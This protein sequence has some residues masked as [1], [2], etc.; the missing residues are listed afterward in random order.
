MKNLNSISI[1]LALAI[2]CSVIIISGCGRQSLT[3]DKG[4]RQLAPVLG[5]DSEDLQYINHAMFAQI[6]DGAEKV[7][8]D[9]IGIVALTSSD[10]IL[11]EGAAS[12]ITEK[13]VLRIPILAIDGFALEGPFL[14]IVHQGDRFVILPYR[15]YSDTVDMAQLHALSE[16]LEAQSIPTSAAADIEWTRRLIYNAEGSG[17]YF[18]GSSSRGG[19]GSSSDDGWGSDSLFYDADGSVHDSPFNTPLN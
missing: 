18:V 6:E 5:S 1:I 2:V 14:Q 3:L 10:L 19:S 16:L 7:D 12:S 17:V 9:M 4:S 11:A 13:E 15:W 8:I